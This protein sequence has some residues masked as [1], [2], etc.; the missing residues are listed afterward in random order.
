MSDLC[1]IND[2]C[3]GF[4]VNPNKIL[5]LETPE[6]RQKCGRA[7][8]DLSL[9]QNVDEERCGQYIHEFGSAALD[10]ASLDFD[11]GNYLIVSTKKR[12]AI[13]T[14]PVI[15]VA[16]NTITLAL[17]RLVF[18]LDFILLEYAT[19]DSSIAV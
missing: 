1:Q 9:N 19:Y 6:H 4:L 8:Y 5:W 16:K 14:G 7:V 17:D 2:L 11:V 15:A 13:A 12:C 3:C 18:F 10:F